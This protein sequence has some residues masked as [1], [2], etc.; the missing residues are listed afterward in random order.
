MITV[1]KHQMIAATHCAGKK[2]LRQYLNGVLVERC[3]N[4]DVHIVGCDGHRIFAGK[5]IT[6]PIV[7]FEP[8][9]IIVPIDAVKL[10]CKGDGAVTIEVF[11]DRWKIGD[12]VFVQPEGRYPDWR[13]VFQFE[14]TN[15]PVVHQVNYEYLVLGEKALQ[16]W[17]QKKH[18]V[19]AKHGAT[20]IRMTTENDLAAVLIMPIR[21]LQFA[22]CSNSIFTPSSF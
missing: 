14:E 19:L 16:T 22:K 21:D 6:D 15:S 12:T 10:S 5:V 2:D 17:V 4:G 1:K 11:A 7:E 9:Q 20:T 18:V 8:L 3:T 13:R